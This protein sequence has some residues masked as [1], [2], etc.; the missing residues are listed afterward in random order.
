[1]GMYLRFQIFHIILKKAFLL[2]SLKLQ[3]YTL[4]HLPDAGIDLKGNIKLFTCLLSACSVLGPIKKS[5]D[6][7]LNYF[8][9]VLI[10]ANLT[11]IQSGSSRIL[12][13]NVRC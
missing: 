1:M 7:L 9:P 11:F 4:F 6:I 2:V 12:E 10:K 8:N 5:T 13:I 3:N